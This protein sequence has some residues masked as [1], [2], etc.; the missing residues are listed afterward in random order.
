MTKIRS[1][2][3]G[4]KNSQALTHATFHSDL[5]AHLQSLHTRV[6]CDA[7]ECNDGQ[8]RTMLLQQRP[9]LARVKFRSCVSLWKVMQSG[10]SCEGEVVVFTSAA[11]THS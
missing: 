4:V 1:G 11:F 5:E 9:Q 3:T 10:T 6:R 7:S 2:H 8:L